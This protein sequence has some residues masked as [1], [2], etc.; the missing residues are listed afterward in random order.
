MV[1]N[2]YFITSNRG[3]FLEAKQFL[4]NFS[5]DLKQ[6]NMDIMEPQSLDIYQVSRFK[7]QN[8]W[9]KFKM[10]LI[11][12]DAGLIF[13]KYN[14]FP[15]ALTKYVMEGIGIN[16]IRDM[17]ENN[18]KAILKSVITYVDID[19]N[20]HSF[21]GECEGKIIIEK[22]YQVNNQ[23]LPYSQVF[24]PSGYD[25]NIESLKTHE[26]MVN[27]HHRIKALQKFVNIHNQTQN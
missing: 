23:Q 9:N 8:A 16:G 24:Y 7:A 21:E 15:G 27:F 26:N 19:G 11:V 18:N 20:I 1:N 14:N 4:E 10:P 2:I 22:D 13:D 5:I 6:E 25:E 3:K 12:D 17:L